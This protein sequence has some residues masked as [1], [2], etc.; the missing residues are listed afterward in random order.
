MAVEE[1][2]LEDLDDLALLVDEVDRH[3]VVPLGLLAAD[4]G[5]QRELRR[6]FELLIDLAE[7]LQVLLFLGDGDGDRV[8][9]RELFVA[10]LQ[11]TE[12]RIAGRSPVRPVHD[13]DDVLLAQVLL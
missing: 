6:R 7:I 13:Q 5:D 10:S 1:K 2:N 8:E 12:L 4:V 3:A 11:L 9:L